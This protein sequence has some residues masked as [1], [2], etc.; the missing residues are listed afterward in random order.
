MYESFNMAKKRSSDA[1]GQAP[2]RP[3]KKRKSAEASKAKMKEIAEAEDVE[4]A[5]LF[6]EVKEKIM[7]EA[8]Q[9]E[10]VQEVERVVAPGFRLWKTTS[11]MTASGELSDAST[12]SVHHLE[13]CGCRS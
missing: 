8:Q 9:N 2:I 4:D 10:D 11:K 12:V 5:E 6:P 13:Q 1:A 3:S 7:I